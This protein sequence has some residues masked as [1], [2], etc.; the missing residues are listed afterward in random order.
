MAGVGVSCALPLGPRFTWNEK[1][2][3]V[4]FLLF[5]WQNDV[6]YFHIVIHDR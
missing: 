4:L 1:K 2:L 6:V 5:K 3:M